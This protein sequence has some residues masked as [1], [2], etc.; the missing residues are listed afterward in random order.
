M[1]NVSGRSG[2]SDI[3]ASDDA[4]NH[5][6]GSTIISQRGVRTCGQMMLLDVQFI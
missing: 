1:R 6:L 2:F 3:V 4:L 5:A